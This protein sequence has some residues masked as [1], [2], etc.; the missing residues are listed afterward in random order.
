MFKKQVVPDTVLS[1]LFNSYKRPVWLRA[2][3][4]SDT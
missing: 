4:L 1:A 3:I 2:I